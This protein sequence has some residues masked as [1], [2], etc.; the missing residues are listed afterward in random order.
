MIKSVVQAIPTYVMG[1]F[2]L[3]KLFLSKLTSLCAKFW[4]GSSEGK[5]KIH[6]MKWDKVCQPKEMGGLNFR[7]FE[8]FNQAL[9]AKQTWRVFSNPQSKLARILKSRYYPN[10]SL[11]QAEAKGSFSYFWKSL[12]GAWSC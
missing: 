11:I 2:R 6:W 12:S 7:D 3:P 4:W 8:G 1:C 5:Q 10:S 9:L